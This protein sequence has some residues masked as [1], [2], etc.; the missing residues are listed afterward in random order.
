MNW[1]LAKVTLAVFCIVIS[2]ANSEKGATV[3]ERRPFRLRYW[4]HI[5]VST[6]RPMII[7]VDIYV[8]KDPHNNGT[9][10]TA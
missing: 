6:G 1:F 8:C 7:A 4:K 5:P 3:E 9:P 2:N 10:K